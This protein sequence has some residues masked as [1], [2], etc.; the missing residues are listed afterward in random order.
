M[1]FK[2]NNE[3]VVE[4]AKR[5]LTGEGGMSIELFV[6]SERE[7][8]V[9]CVRY[10]SKDESEV[11]ELP[12]RSSKEFAEHLFAFLRKSCL[13][14]RQL[15]GQV[16][17]QSECSDAHAREDARLFLN[18]L[19]LAGCFQPREAR[20]WL[21]AEKAQLLSVIINHPV[22]ELMPQDRYLWFVL[23]KGAS[24]E[25]IVELPRE[26]DAFCEAFLSW[27]RAD[28]E[29]MRTILREIWKFLHPRA[30]ILFDP[31]MRY[32]LATYFIE[33][34]DCEPMRSIRLQD[35]ELSWHY[36]A[37]HRLRWEVAR[38]LDEDRQEKATLEWIEVCYRTEPTEPAMV[39]DWDAEKE[40]RET[41]GLGEGTPLRQKLTERLR[42]WSR[43]TPQR[44]SSI[45]G[46]LIRR[47]QERQTLTR[48]AHWFVRRYE[49][50]TAF[51]VI[52]VSFWLSLFLLLLLLVFAALALFFSHWW[53][54]VLFILSLV[55]PVALFRIECLKLG[56][57]IGRLVG[58][59][60]IGWLPLLTEE[61]WRLALTNPS[62]HFPSWIDFL[63]VA[64][65]FIVVG[66]ICLEARRFL[67]YNR[68]S[69]WELFKRS[70]QIVLLGL[71]L[72]ALIGLFLCR[73][74]GPAVLKGIEGQISEDCRAP[75][76]WFLKGLYGSSND[77]FPLAILLI[78][79]PLAM[80]IGI[81]I[82]I[83]WEEKPLTEPL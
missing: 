17:L 58:G 54:F 23:H 19:W 74:A 73:F 1:G 28:E 51:Q 35:E 66:Y 68:I 78:H 59:C 37:W 7:K 79:S 32:E 83:L 77:V 2:A 76:L 67:P 64:A 45:P 40:I 26:R 31:D 30:G 65:F 14:F 57:M 8:Q 18:W 75:L 81:F 22:V 56:R 80:F 49:L 43:T 55:V 69:S 11:F 25:E 20:N 48:L 15:L 72:S 46:F 60:V 13:C 6:W 50:P 82:Q 61:W 39:T 24:S 3:G 4:G 29:A 34:M 33:A 9:F 21:T 12:Y 53:A 70:S 10:K 41:L 44:G 47:E 63:P 42:T 52:G 71:L 36:C 27:W 16:E 5:N 62:G 38:E